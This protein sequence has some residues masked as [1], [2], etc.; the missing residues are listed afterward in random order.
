MG[1]YTSPYQCG[2]TCDRGPIAVFH[3]FSG[4][5]QQILGV[6][7]SHSNVKEDLL[8][9]IVVNAT[10]AAQ[11]AGHLVDIITTDAAS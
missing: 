1:P 7:G 3:S 10:M 11:K 6:C 2:Q 5:F 4:D 8:S 9:K